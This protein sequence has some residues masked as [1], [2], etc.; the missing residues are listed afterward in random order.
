V[1]WRRERDLA[2][3][4]AAPNCFWLCARVRLWRDLVFNAGRNFREH[5][6]RHQTVLLQFAKLR[7]Q[8]VLGDSGNRLSQLA[9]AVDALIQ[10]PH[11]FKLPFA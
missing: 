5:G 2:L 1:T 11:D 4:S 6:A 3:A 7:R 9:E 8:H 10:Q